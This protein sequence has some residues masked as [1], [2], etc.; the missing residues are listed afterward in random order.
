MASFSKGVQ[1]TGTIVR[2]H[3][4]GSITLDFAYGR[5]VYCSTK[6]ASYKAQLH[7]TL[8]MEEGCI[9]VHK[10]PLVHCTAWTLNLVYN[11]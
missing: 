7:W 11:S 2:I 10:K 4:G 5:R 1:L 3:L 6:E 9:V 8:L